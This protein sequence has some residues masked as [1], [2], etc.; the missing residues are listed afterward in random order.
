VSSAVGV[1]YIALWALYIIGGWVV[2]QKAGEAGWKVLIPIYNIIVLLK[3]VGKPWWWLILLLIPL[4]N[5]IFGIIVAYDLAK[6]FGHGGGFTVG[7]VL[8]P[9]I[10]ILILAFGSSQY[11]GPGGTP[12]LDSS[13]GDMGGPP[14]QAT[15]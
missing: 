9:Y 10:F 14:A 12:A 3:I 11:I 7:L 5:I 13:S 15:W 4:V 2:F 6:S 1:I 8:L